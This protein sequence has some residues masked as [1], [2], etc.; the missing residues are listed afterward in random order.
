MTS[1]E[2]KLGCINAAIHLSKVFQY[3]GEGSEID[4]KFILDTADELYDYVIKE[5]L[6][7]VQP[8]PIIPTTQDHLIKQQS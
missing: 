4:I 1:P 5:T 7:E 6:H 3:D 8:Q 2:L